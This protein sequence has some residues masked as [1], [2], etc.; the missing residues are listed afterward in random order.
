[1]VARI[2]SLLLASSLLVVACPR[3]A[4]A[5]WP[6][7]GVPATT[8]TA[9]QTGP[10]AAADGAGGIILAWQDLR[11]DGGD[12]YAQRLTPLGTPTEGWPAGGLPVCTAS[13]AQSAAAIVADGRGGAFVAWQDKRSGPYPDLYV[14]HVLGNG[15]VD[16][17]WP[18]NGAPLCTA[19]YAQRTPVLAL[20]G[21]FNPDCVAAGRLA[22]HLAPISHPRDAGH[23]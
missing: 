19:A 11:S 21:A 16:P 17:A 14:Q 10:A 5:D 7:G 20:D 12:I 4:R 9:S 18:T 22:L 2:A 15:T 3:P 8:S 1:M 13:G 6:P 23:E